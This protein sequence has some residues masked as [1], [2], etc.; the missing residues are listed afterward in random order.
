VVIFRLVGYLYLY[1]LS[2]CSILL[3]YL[4]LGCIGSSKGHLQFSLME[5]LSLSAFLL[6]AVKNDLHHSHLPSSPPPL[7]FIEYPKP[8]LSIQILAVLPRRTFPLTHLLISK[9]SLASTFE[10][11][12]IHSQV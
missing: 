3:P 10:R 11:M 4:S 8:L 5:I 1:S 6:N 2:N 7:I 12:N 9:S